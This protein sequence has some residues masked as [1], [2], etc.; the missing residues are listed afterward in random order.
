MKRAASAALA[1]SLLFA[2][3]GN[4][5]GDPAGPG[6]GNGTV[7]ATVDGQA[8]SGSLA[9]QAVYSQGVLAFGATQTAGVGE[10]KQFNINL[11]SVNGEGT[12]T[13]GVGSINVAIYTE[14]QGQ[15]ISSWTT[16]L[17]GGQGT[18]ELEE[19]TATSASGTFTLTMPASPNTSATGTKT[20]INGTFDVEIGG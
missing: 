6:S 15:N 17:P 12:Y 18:L 14:T 5:D 4:D 16:S 13:F 19:L 10:V 1:A 7:T 11:T 9:V 8:F 20:V 3:C 2:A